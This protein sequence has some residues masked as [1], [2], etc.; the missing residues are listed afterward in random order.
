[1]ALFERLRPEDQSSISRQIES[2]VKSI[3]ES[4]ALSHVERNKFAA[5]LSQLLVSNPTLD[6]Y[7]LILSD[8]SDLEEIFTYL[9]Q[10]KQPELH[11]KVTELK[12]SVKQYL[13]KYPIDK[14]VEVSS[15]EKLYGS[16]ISTYKALYRNPWTRK[17]AE[18]MAENYLGKIIQDSE[19]EKV[20]AK[21]EVK[22]NK[23]PEHDTEPSDEEFFDAIQGP[24]IVEQNPH[25]KLIAEI[26]ERI[27]RENVVYDPEDKLCYYDANDKEESKITT[28][29]EQEKKKLEII[30]DIKPLS[31]FSVANIINIVTKFTSVIKDYLV[32]NLFGRSKEVVKPKSEIQIEINASNK[33]NQP[34]VA[35]TS[36][37]DQ[38]RKYSDLIKSKKEAH[39]KGH[40]R[41]TR[42]D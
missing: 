5:G 34:I 9:D 38:P 23:L 36:I 21:Q 31:F 10:L 20:P 2:V 35:K 28:P 19:Q 16:T 40:I 32:D 33:T 27:K 26:A 11:A 8:N 42:R 22:T 18:T 1:M 37:Q 7:D 4:N 39:S 15:L 13:D 30:V 41:I 6:K 17:T 14:Y 3:A 24:E 12:G 25:K 29:K